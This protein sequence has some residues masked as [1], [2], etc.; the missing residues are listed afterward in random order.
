MENLHIRIDKW[1]WMVRLFKTR[2]LATE[3]CNA[4]KV[5]CNGVN[6]KPSKEVKTE[7]EYEVHI[8]ALNKQVRVLGTPKSRVGAALVPDYC[9]DLTPQEEYDRMKTLHTYEYRPHG[10][11]RPT[12]RDRRQ[13]EYI[14]S[15]MGDGEE[16]F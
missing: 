4:G 12:K 9:E 8:G 6:V 2:S 13:L 14:K 1:L 3:A 16:E 15:M 11:G 10:L 5:K 7:E